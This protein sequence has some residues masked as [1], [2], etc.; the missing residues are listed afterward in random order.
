MIIMMM[1]NNKQLEPRRKTRKKSRRRYRKPIIFL[2][3]VLSSI[4]IIMSAIAASE[5]MNVRSAGMNTASVVIPKL[6]GGNEKNTEQG[7]IPGENEQEQQTDA[8]SASGSDSEAKDALPEN[9]QEPESQAD[10]S[11][12]ATKPAKDSKASVPKVVYLTF[13]DGPSKYT[14]DIV[15]ILNEH[16]I[17][18]TFFVIGSQIKG[19]EDSLKAASEQGNYIGLHSMTHDKNI[20]Y[21]SGSSA[22]FLKEFSK[23]QG[24]VEE[25]TGTAPWL[26]RAPYGSMPQIGKEFRNDIVKAGFKM[27]DWTIDSKD[28]KYTNHPDKVMQEIKSQTHRDVE[29][30]LLHEKKQ[31]VEVLP[32]IIEYLTNKGYAFAVYKPE[33]H[34][35][36][37]FADDQRL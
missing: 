10:S 4:A 28:W 6:N 17:H 29:V 30:I 22:K 27:W 11:A 12:N 9:S 21:K 1:S 19:R 34:F 2:A 37:N 18:A 33:Q 35:S 23:V 25:I 15:A 14:D 5:H 20:L 16:G 3:L 32:Q 26:I 7:I 36:V 13:D 8:P 24:M 31:T